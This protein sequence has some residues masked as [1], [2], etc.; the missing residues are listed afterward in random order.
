MNNKKPKNQK[1]KKVKK[2]KE[3]NK[4]KTIEKK[5]KKILR[6]CGDR[7]NPKDLPLAYKEFI[8][9]IPKE[10]LRLS[11]QEDGTI[12][13][14][15][16]YQFIL[17]RLNKVVGFEHWNIKIIDTLQ[18]EKSSNLWLVALLIELSLGNY[19]AGHFVPLVSK[20]S[21]GSG[22]DGLLG[23]AKKGALTNGFKKVA[24]MFGIGKKAYEGLIED[25]DILEK[26][27][28]K[29][30]KVE[31][32]LSE[33]QKEMTINFEKA[34]MK[35]RDKEGLLE[36]EKELDKV[37]EKLGDIQVKYVEKLINKLKKKFQ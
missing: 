16:G 3:K 32:V 20:I 29:I 13:T 28:G 27:R 26:D 34:L 19:V 36:V 12:W 35:V 14:L 9:E 4:D 6:V 2:S 33:A 25:Y 37:K 5:K 18:T 15:Y 10:A 21:F 17:N 1:N 24:A 22:T 8:K 23:N 7:L 11:K 30:V 31:A